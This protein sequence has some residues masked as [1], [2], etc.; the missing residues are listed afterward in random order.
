MKRLI[1][2]LLLC[3][4]LAAAAP[5]A[6][7]SDCEQTKLR[8]IN[9]K[10]DGSNSDK[11]LERARPVPVSVFASIPVTDAQYAAV[12]GKATVVT[13]AAKHDLATAIDRIRALDKNVIDVELGATD[14]K[15]FDRL[16][17]RAKRRV[18]LIIGHE[19][20][21]R[22]R[23]L[24]G[25]DMSV[26]DMAAACSAHDAFCVFLLCETETLLAGSPCSA[27]ASCLVSADR[28]SRA[29]QHVASYAA[30]AP[31]ITAKAVQDAIRN[32]ARAEQRALQ[33]RAVLAEG[34]VIAV[35]DTIYE[36]SNFG[37]R[38]P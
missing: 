15:A 32:G 12:Y 7:E 11:Q 22:F 10:I 31:S 6:I 21:G 18:V 20:E 13:A 29:V 26:L 38:K 2:L 14:R 8:R 37:S 25:S 28:A 16:T 36:T 5:A 27:G 9:D 19:L 3:T 34:F 17:A 23:F 4:E 35:I 33:A 24:N 1:A 30:A